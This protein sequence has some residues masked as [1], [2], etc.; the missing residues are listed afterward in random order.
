M[1]TK[2]PRER[3]GAQEYHEIPEGKKR[4]RTNEV[5]I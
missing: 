2:E 1:E 3:E 4:M 5:F